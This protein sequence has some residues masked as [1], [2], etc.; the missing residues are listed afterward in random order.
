MKWILISLCASS[1]SSSFWCPFVYVLQYEFVS[2]LLIMCL[3][4]GYCAEQQAF[5]KAPFFWFSRL[6]KTLVILSVIVDYCWSFKCL[7][8]F[9]EMSLASSSLRLAL[10]SWS[11]SPAG[12]CLRV[13]LVER[14]TRWCPL[15]LAS[16]CEGRGLSSVP[17][18]EE[19]GRPKQEAEI[20]ARIKHTHTPLFILQ[21]W[22]RS[23][24]RQAR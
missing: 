23:R 10:M 14:T 17:G 13:R 7:S 5:A 18:E 12:C 8:P 2:L 22:T 21:M 24:E 16:S 1:P 15:K 19:R 6:L 11:V 3:C 4:P 9:L 20:A